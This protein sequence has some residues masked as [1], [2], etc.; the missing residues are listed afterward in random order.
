VG[1]KVLAVVAKAVLG[2]EMVVTAVAG[3]ALVGWAMR[4]SSRVG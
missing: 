1:Q 2:A 4:R 3:D